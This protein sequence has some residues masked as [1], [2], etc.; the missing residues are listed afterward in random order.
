MEITS[1][2]LVNVFD[3]INERLY[4]IEKNQNL[5]ITHC[6]NKCLSEGKLD[7]DLFGYPMNVIVTNECK[8]N[9]NEYICVNLHISHTCSDDYTTRWFEIFEKKHYNKVKDIL[10]KLFNEKQ[11]KILHDYVADKSKHIYRLRCSTL[12]IKTIYSFVDEYIMNAYLKHTFKKVHMIIGWYKYEIILKDMSCVD[13]VVEY[14]KTIYEHLD[15]LGYNNFE[16]WVKTSTNNFIE[17][18]PIYAYKTWLAYHLITNMLP[19]QLP[20]E[21]LNVREILEEYQIDKGQM[22]MFIRTYQLEQA[23]KGHKEKNII[24]IINNMKRIVAEYYP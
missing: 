4:S 7:K 22:Y 2:T 5:L 12:D 9:Y 15:F 21:D 11:L 17:I 13:E 18:T 14:V 19:V 20:N 1:Q 24:G 3:M 23:Q 16:M 8:F 10:P 6:K